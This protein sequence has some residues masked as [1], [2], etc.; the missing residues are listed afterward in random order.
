MN[1]VFIHQNFPGQFRHIAA[2]LAASAGNSVV[3]ICKS[4]APRLE[5]VRAVAYAPARGVTK[6]IHRYLVSTER[7]V[8]NGRAVAR[9]VLKLTNQGFRPDVVIAQT[10]WGEALYIKDVL[11]DVPL[12]GYFEFFYHGTGADVGFDP[13]FPVAADVILKVRTRNAPQFLS[14]NAVD[15]GVVPT[16]W[17]RSVFP[18]E[19]HSKL[20]L[21][22]EGVNA[23]KAVPRADAT[24]QL[25]DGRIL[26]RNDEVVTYVAR[27]LE[28]Y[29][30]FHI[31][32]RAAAEIL[33]RRPSAHVIIVG[34]DGVSYGRRLPVG[35]TYRERML[36]EVDLDRN[37]VHFL[38]T[39]NYDKY[40]Q[41][42]QVSSVHVYLTVPFVLSWSMLEAMS[43]GCIVLASDTPPVTEVIE[44]GKNGLLVNF[45]SHQ[46]IADAVDRVFQGEVNG[47]DIRARARNT[48]L[49]RYSI[50]D[51]IKAYEALFAEMAG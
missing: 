24:L 48:I 19:Y 34:G 45:F 28:P 4:Y 21:I 2:H 10:G 9:A 37:R 27:N 43:A 39:L 15:A 1:I 14:L 38:G 22:H 46:G 3:S 31:F 40:L 33:R 42:L 11:P 50:A 25:R 26:T 41:V 18:R 20:R 12:I 49:E 17:Q 8:L 44:H 23:D 30:G 32:M 13:E 47:A 36:G 5:T 6:G 35:Q 16:A 29:R 7:A 51:G